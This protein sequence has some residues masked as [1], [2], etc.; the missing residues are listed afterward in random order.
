L[1][2]LGASSPKRLELMYPVGGALLAS[3]KVNINYC[4]CGVKGIRYMNEQLH[5]KKGNKQ[6]STTFLEVE[7]SVH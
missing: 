1:S 2:A 7:L 5:K 3:S 6:A 4:E